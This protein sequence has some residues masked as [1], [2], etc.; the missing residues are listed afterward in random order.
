MAQPIPGQARMVRS[1][2]R[3]GGEPV[4][5]VVG[6]GLAGR[7][8]T[9]GR[10][11]RIRRHLPLGIE[12]RSQESGEVT[13]PTNEVMRVD[14]GPLGAPQ[15]DLPGERGHGACRGIERLS[16]PRMPIGLLHVARLTVALELG[17]EIGIA[18]AISIAA[19]EPLG[20]GPDTV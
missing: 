8:K 17:I 12:I 13:I 4:G 1:R 11:L 7:R 18:W 3:V 9:G 14:N 10:E 16:R 19:G 20:I 5:V 2:T 6:T 15:P